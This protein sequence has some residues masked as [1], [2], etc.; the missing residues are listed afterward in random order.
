MRIAQLAQAGREKRTKKSNQRAIETEEFTSDLDYMCNRDAYFGVFL[1]NLI[2]FHP[3]SE[4]SKK[5]IKS[6][7]KEVKIRVDNIWKIKKIENELGNKVNFLEAY[8]LNAFEKNGKFSQESKSL[9]Y[10]ISCARNLS[11][12]YCLL[13]AQEDVLS[14]KGSYDNRFQEVI[15]LMEIE[16][17][18]ESKFSPK[19]ILRLA[20][21]EIEKKTTFSE[22]QRELILTY[23]HKNYRK[24]KEMRMEKV[25]SKAYSKNKE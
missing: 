17:S 16:E 1:L 4:M 10:K 5:M 12:Y 13:Y 15:R 6:A 9:E 19:I 22:S 2:P 25:I 24:V 23:M 18:F 3:F 14:T 7:D 21:Y 8:Y 20:K 11:A